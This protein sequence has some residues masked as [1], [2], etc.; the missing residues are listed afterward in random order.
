MLATGADEAALDT[1]AADRHKIAEDVVALTDRMTRMATLRSPAGRALSNIAIGFA[2]HIPD[3]WPSLGPD[4]RE[5]Q[6]PG[7]LETAPECRKP[8]LRE[9]LRARDQAEDH[10]EAGHSIY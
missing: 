6:Q 8:R 5:T 9:M 4:C 3:L 10:D 7:L 1:W 2:G